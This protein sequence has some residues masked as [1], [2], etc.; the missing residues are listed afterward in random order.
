MGL[1]LIFVVETNKKNKSDWMYINA[2]LKHFYQTNDPHLK[3]TPIYMNGKTKYEKKLNEINNAIKQYAAGGKNRHSKV[4]Y[5]FD[6][7]NYDTD[8]VDQQFLNKAQYYCN[9][10]GYEFVWFCKDIEHVYLGHQIPAN[11]KKTEA[12]KFLRTGLISKLDSSVL[13]FDKYQKKTSNIMTIIN[14][15]LT[16]IT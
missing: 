5:C 1:Q 7:D 8:S 9:N 4:I 13:S 16:P 11:M 15:Y 3:I 14:K 12:E 6:C 2:T 10:N